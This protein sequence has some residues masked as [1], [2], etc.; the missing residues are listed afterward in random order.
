MTTPVH[1]LETK[2]IHP[3]KAAFSAAERFHMKAQSGSLWAF[4]ASNPLVGGV[5]SLQRFTFSVI[6]D[7]EIFSS[8]STE[9]ETFVYA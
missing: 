8:V 6:R 1:R 5:N 3:Q 9:N 4:P 7:S 2:E